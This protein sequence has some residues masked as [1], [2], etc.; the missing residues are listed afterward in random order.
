MKVNKSWKT[1]IGVVAGLAMMGA[2]ASAQSNGPLGISARI[3]VFLPTGT[4]GENLGHTWFAAGL[5]YKINTVPVTTPTQYAGLPSYLSFSAD[6]YEKDSDYA[7]PVALNYNIRVKQFVFSAGI[8]AEATQNGGGN[9]TI[10]LA[11]QVA[12]AYDITTLPVPV[13]LQAKYFI[14]GKNEFR[15]VGLFAGVRF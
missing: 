9:S 15:G 2:V 14:S 5:D 1:K 6:Y 7:I 13:F 11:G 4:V 12:A 10:G 8:G 3:G